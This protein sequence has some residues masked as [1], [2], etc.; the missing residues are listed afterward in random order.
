M[1]NSL[2][3]GASYGQGEI[4]DLL[5]EFSSFKERVSEK[6]K[7]IS[8]ELEGNANKHELWVTI[9]RMSADYAEEAFAKKLK[10]E[11]STQETS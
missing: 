9:Y 2:R 10:Q 1:V 5:S 7:K 11:T 4:L 6:F 3:D 8:E